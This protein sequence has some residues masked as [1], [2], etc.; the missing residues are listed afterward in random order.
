MPVYTVRRI[1]RESLPVLS[2]LIPFAIFAGVFLH[3]R[4]EILTGLPVLLVLVPPFIDLIGDVT[5]VFSARMTTALHLGTIEPT[6]KST[7]KIAKEVGL[8]YGAGIFV[9]SFLAALAYGIALAF[10]WSVLPLHELVLIVVAAGALSTG[11]LLVVAIVSAFGVFRYGW[12]PD[13]VV[14]PIL[15]T[16]GDFIGVGHFLII[17]ELIA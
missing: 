1:T 3:A 6:A 5:G 17:L 14:A 11:V 7:L 9:F 10:G 4:L 12:D 15:T 16:M 2:S 8:I 13:N